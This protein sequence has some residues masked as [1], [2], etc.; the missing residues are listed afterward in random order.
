MKINKL[1]IRNF[2][3]FGDDECVIDLHKR[4]PIL[5]CGPN[6]SGKTSIVESIIWCLFGRLS[7]I[8][9]PGDKIIN[10][11]TGKNC[12]VKII[13]DDGYEIC[14]TRK[15]EGCSD[16]LIYKDG[17]VI[18]DGDSTNTNAQA[19]LQ[20]IFKLD[21]N[22][23]ISS[24]F[25]GQSSGSFLSFGD[26]KKKQIIESLFGLSKLNYYAK[27]AKARIEECEQTHSRMKQKAADIDTI[28]ASIESDISKYE[29]L[30]KEFEDNRIKTI[31]DQESEIKRLN[32][33]RQNPIDIDKLTAAWDIINK[34]VQKVD[35]FKSAKEQL[36]TRIQ[37]I[38]DDTTKLIRSKD[39]IDGEIVLI[40][41]KKKQVQDQQDG[42]NDKRGTICPTCDQDVPNSL[43]D[44]KIEEIAKKTKEELDG[45]DQLINSHKKTLSQ[46]DA[47]MSKLK[48]EVPIVR[49]KII[50]ID[51][52][53]KKLTESIDKSKSGKMTI[54]EATKHNELISNI[55]REITKCT[56]EILLT[57]NKKNNYNDMVVTSKLRIKDY[58]NTKT[59]L[60]EKMTKIA[61]EASHLTYIYRAHSDKKNIRSFLISGSIPILND[62]LS[63]YFNELGICTDIEFN[64]MLQ[65]KSDKWPYEMHS[66]GEKKRIDL[67]LMCALYDTFVS[68]YGQRSN[69]LLLDELD[70]EFDHEGVEE[71]VKLIIDD[72]SNRIDTILVISH[73]EEITYAFP[74]QIKIKNEGSSVLEHIS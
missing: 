47:G 56:A 22:S 49:N 17:N 64:Q 65:I 10:W 46:I 8:H 73:K 6:G 44:K 9:N 62:R 53:I 69:V 51:D 58:D 30:S 32:N 36:G 34:S 31:E 41:R 5:I 37:E 20:K 11:N 18:E 19:T 24:I 50:A 12:M 45:Y 25:F 39:K 28:V 52:N 66:G 42:W 14:R 40:E 68:M 13:T 21:F 60:N 1:H 54:I 48:A 2:K 72:L 29:L 63:Y 15:F 26:S 33:E 38:T 59:E 43:I 7:D 3:S 74:T 57:S 35:S 55:D 61:N 67:A 4:G 27:V 16:L 71:Y 70:K 23:F